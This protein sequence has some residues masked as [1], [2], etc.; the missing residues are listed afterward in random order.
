MDLQFFK[1]QGTGNDFVILDN[2]NGQYDA[3]T[4]EQVNWICNRRF[5]IGADGLMMLNT[6]TG[7][8]F[9]M[10][11]YNADG[12]PSTMCGNG[13]RCLVKFAWHQGI[14]RPMYKFI[15]AD[16]DH[17]AEIDDDGTVAL[18]MKDVS[19]IKDYHG[20]FILDTGSPH[21]VK[22]VT[23]VMEMDVYKKGM[24]IR[25]SNHFAKEGINVNFVEQKKED[26]ITVRTYERGVE[27][28]TYS[29][30][31]G[32]TAA[33]LVCYHNERG[34]NDVTVHT[35]GGRLTVEYDRVDDD[36]FENVWLCGPAERVFAGT[37]SVPD[38][39]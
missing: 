35:K 23:D 7:Y 36:T 27:D 39:S 15:A 17:E 31:T 13:G 21:Y 22:I 29:C 10:K 8:D 25:Y 33:A 16:G 6:K 11:Y 18:K 1:Y 24:D 37:I 14:R 3:L 34:F 9:E 2:R 30:G 28:E 19:A 26:E 12:R 38:A 4:N 32:V 20:D 5:G